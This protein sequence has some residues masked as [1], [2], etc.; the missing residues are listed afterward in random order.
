MEP[1]KFTVFCRTVNMG[2]VTVHKNH[3]FFAEGV[4]FPVSF[5]EAFPL[6]H[7]NQE[8]AVIVVPLDKIFLCAEIMADT[9]RI[10]KGLFCGFARS[11][12]IDCRFWGTTDIYGAHTGV[13]FLKRKG[14]PQGG[15]SVAGIRPLKKRAAVV[16]LCVCFSIAGESSGVKKRAIF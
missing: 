13:P 14:S 12:K 7:I 9:E 5:Q 3:I 15:L 1:E 16:F 6:F 10:E 11:V 4:F 8:K 2:I